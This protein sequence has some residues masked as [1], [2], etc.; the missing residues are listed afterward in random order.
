MIGYW[1]QFFFFFLFRIDAASENFRATHK[2]WQTFW[3]RLFVHSE[4]LISWLYSNDG[5]YSSFYIFV[6]LYMQTKSMKDH[7]PHGAAEHRAGT[8]LIKHNVY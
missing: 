7:R 4:I 5:I 2:D 1:R 6:V 8:M 3:Y